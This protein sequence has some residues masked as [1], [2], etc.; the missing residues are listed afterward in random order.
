MGSAFPSTRSALPSI[1]AGAGSGAVCPRAERDNL[2]LL[3]DFFEL[4][5]LPD[6]GQLAAT[7]VIHCSMFT[8]IVERIPTQNTVS[9]SRQLGLIRSC[10]V[11][12]LIQ[13]IVII[14]KHTKSTKFPTSTSSSLISRIIATWVIF[15]V[16]ER[17]NLFSFLL[18][19]ESIQQYFISI[20]HF[21]ANKESD[22]NHF[23][24]S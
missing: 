8:T 21:G 6:P 15:Y 1:R 17:E 2:P 10:T 18:K 14:R 11:K 12:G 16:S 9:D 5:N 24:K 23:I 19:F 4:D 22:L 7:I 13:I 20:L 3:Q